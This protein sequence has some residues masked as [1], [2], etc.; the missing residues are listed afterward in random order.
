MEVKRLVRRDDIPPVRPH[1]LRHGA[2]T[3]ALMAGADKKVVPSRPTEWCTT[4]P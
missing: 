3:M 4:G 1:D 2:A